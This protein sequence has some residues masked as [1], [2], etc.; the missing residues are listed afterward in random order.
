MSDFTTELCETGRVRSSKIDINP[1]GAWEVWI[2]ISHDDAD[3]STRIAAAI[4]PKE[5]R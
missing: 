5:K 1:E 3:R 2:E 4:T